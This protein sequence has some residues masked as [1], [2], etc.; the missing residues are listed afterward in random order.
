MSPDLNLRRVALIW[1]AIAGAF[2]GYDI[3][4]DTGTA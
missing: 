2:Y 4:R 3:L 1:I